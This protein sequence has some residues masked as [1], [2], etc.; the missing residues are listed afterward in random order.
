[1]ATVTPITQ[2]ITQE[3]QETTRVPES[4]TLTLSI[5]EAVAV[6]AVIGAVYGNQNTTIRHYTSPVFWALDALKI[7]A[8]SPGDS[9]DGAGISLGTVQAYA[10]KFRTSH[11]KKD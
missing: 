9:I 10:N 7:H 6:K 11:T 8:P 5:E 4:I 3:V 1:M 2:Q